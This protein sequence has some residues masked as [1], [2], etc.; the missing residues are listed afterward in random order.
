LDF[1]EHEDGWQKGANCVTEVK[2]FETCLNELVV[3]FTKEV[4]SLVGK[5]NVVDTPQT[6]EGWDSENYRTFGFE[7]TPNFPQGLT[8]IVQML[9]DIQHSDKVKGV[10]VK[11]EKL[12]VAEH[13]MFHSP[14]AGEF[15]R[16]RRSVKSNDRAPIAKQGK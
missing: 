3:N 13:E 14:L 5:C 9:K 2:Q 8:V 6:H 11:G 16:N 12:S 10:I 7:D 1:P 15:Q 4:S